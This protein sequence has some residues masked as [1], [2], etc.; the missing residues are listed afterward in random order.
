MYAFPNANCISAVYSSAYTKLS[1]HKILRS[2]R[3]LLYYMIM[4]F[5]FWPTVERLVDL[6]PDN[7]G[8][9][10]CSREQKFVRKTERTVESMTDVRGLFYV[11]SMMI[12]W[13]MFL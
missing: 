8:C 13:L 3:L 11:V 2:T 5:L 6:L 10:I 7:E 1:Y 12:C 4:R 9:T